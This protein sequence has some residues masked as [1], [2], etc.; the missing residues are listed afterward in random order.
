MYPRVRLVSTSWPGATGSS[1]VG[2]PLP[3][4]EGEGIDSSS[5]APAFTLGWWRCSG[6][7][8]AVGWGY[9]VLGTGGTAGPSGQA[10]LSNAPIA[11][12]GRGAGTGSLAKAGRAAAVATAV[13]GGGGWPPPRP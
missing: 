11:P 8:H 5:D 12:R 4:P 1:L 3:P 6:L 10:A 9:P 13:A 7:T 2:D